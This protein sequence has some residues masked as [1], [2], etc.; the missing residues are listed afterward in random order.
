MA[1]SNNT[2]YDFARFEPKRREQAPEI[3]KNNVIPLPKE[4]IEKNARPRLHPLRVVSTL[5][6][7]LVIL[8][9]V[10]SLVYG[11]VRLTELTDS[12]NSTEKALSE[13]ESVYTQLQMK[14]DALMSLDSVEAYA[15]QN[16]GMQKAEKDQVEYISMAQEDQGTVLQDA[17]G[18]GILDQIWNWFQ[19]LL[20]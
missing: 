6:V 15:E 11:Q 10:G 18:Q 20:G 9:T 8:A 19:Q 1:V 2:A 16:L 3:Q 13:S 4:Q 17:G 12:I 14:S 7:M 5:A